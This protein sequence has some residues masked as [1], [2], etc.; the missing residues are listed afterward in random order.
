VRPLIILATAAGLVASGCGSGTETETVTVAGEAQ[1][2]TVEETVEEV[3]TETV[4]ETVKPKPKPKPSGGRTFT[5]NGSKEI[6]PIAVR[7]GGDLRWRCPGN[8]YGF[9]INDEDFE[10]SVTS[11]AQSGDTY[12]APGT[13]RG[14]QIDGSCNWTVTFPR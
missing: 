6:P 10:I 8:E 7:S 14:V 13:Y 5:G 2:V 12:V 3:V 4:T 11:E 1:T 9:Y